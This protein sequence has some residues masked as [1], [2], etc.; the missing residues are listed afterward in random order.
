MKRVMVRYKVKADRVVEHEG[1]ITG[2]FQQLEREKPDGLSYACFRLDDG[3]SYVHIATMERA[4]IRNPL[5]DLSAF[6][7]FI[8]EIKDRCEELPVSVELKE[9]G[10]YGFLGK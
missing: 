8:S 6:K 10:S 2:V 4:D 7:A 3:A 5:L 9:V 1:Y